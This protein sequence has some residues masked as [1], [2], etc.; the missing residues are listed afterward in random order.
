MFLIKTDYFQ[1]SGS[2]NVSFGLTV[3]NNINNAVN[4]VCGV[5]KIKNLFPILLK[6]EREAHLVG[7]LFLFI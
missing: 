7:A 2:E 5:K 3:I 6:E 1:L 4:V